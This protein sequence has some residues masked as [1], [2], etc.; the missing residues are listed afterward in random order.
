MRHHR[1]SLPLLLSCIFAAPSAFAQSAPVPVT[2]ESVTWFS[3]PNN[4]SLRA[5]WML[6]A[7]Q[8]AAAYV[9]HVVLSKGGRIPPHTHP[10][11]RVV[12]VLHGTLLVAFGER[13]G[14]ADMVPVSAGSVYVVPANMPHA[15][16][17]KEGDVTYQETGIGPTGN[18]PIAE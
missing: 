14:D 15:L 16:W 13:P 5:A 3:P 10:D 1:N 4:P 7:E 8:E 6:G 12:T 17:A 18:Y 2:P 11:T 9:L